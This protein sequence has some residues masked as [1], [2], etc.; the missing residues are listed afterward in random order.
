MFGN[1]G[2]K[3]GE[4]AGIEKSSMSEGTEHEHVPQHS[5]EVLIY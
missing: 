3:H 5:A 1:I 2:H 4:G